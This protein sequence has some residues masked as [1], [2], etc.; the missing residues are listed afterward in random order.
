MI[1][2]ATAGIEVDDFRILIW[3]SERLRFGRNAVT[4]LTNKKGNTKSSLQ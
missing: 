1:S 2:V 3:H 4:N